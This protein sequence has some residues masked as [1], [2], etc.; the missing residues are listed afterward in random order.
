MSNYPR[1][2]RYT[3]EHEWVKLSEDGTAFI[4]VTF[5]A[6]EQLGD[7]VY[8]SLPEPGTVL[9]QFAKLGEVESVKAV[10]DIYC[11]LSSEV[12]EKN[13]EAEQHPELLN[14]DPYGKGWLLKLRSANPREIEGLL[15][16]EQ[17]E[18][19]LKAEGH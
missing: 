11:P 17:Y 5:F 18:A 3:K 7:V 4:G 8:L 6:Q 9:A 16:A 1:D 10:S 19:L 13:R 2:L 15:T 12:L 14:Q